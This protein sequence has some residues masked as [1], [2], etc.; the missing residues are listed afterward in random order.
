[1]KVSLR[2]SCNN[3]LVLLTAK[4]PQKLPAENGLLNLSLVDR[5]LTPSGIKPASPPDNS[6]KILNGAAFNAGFIND[7]SMIF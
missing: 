1:M 4:V 6:L 3:S 2:Y 7:L 5:G